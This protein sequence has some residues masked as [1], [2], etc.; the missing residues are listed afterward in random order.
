MLRTMTACS[1]ALRRRPSIRRIAAVIVVALLCSS[2]SAQEKTKTDGVAN[3]KAESGAQA[4]TKEGS[5]SLPR[6]FRGLTLGMS[7]DALKKALAADELF[8]FR[9]DRDV[10]LLPQ[11]DQT[12]IE[13]TGL[14]FIRRAFFQLKDGSLFMMAFSLDVDKVDHY[15][16]FSTFVSDYGEPTTLDPSQAVW[17]SADTRVSIER[18]LT[19]KYI[20]RS[21]FDK[22]AQDSRTK[23]SREAIL[24]KEFLDGF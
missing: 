10:S 19:V 4:P 1:G 18:P 20:D 21:V 5:A 24:R 8:N 7:L 13:T 3:P 15:S 9:G 23:E 12:L 16:V 11:T 22:L 6:A 14:S 2:A 17:L